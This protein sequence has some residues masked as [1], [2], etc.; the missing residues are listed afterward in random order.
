MSCCP[1]TFFAVKSGH[2]N[3]LSR[4][5]LEELLKVNDSGQ[6]LLHLATYIGNLKIIKYIISKVPCLIDYRNE[7]HE[8]PL[9]IAS[10]FGHINIINTFINTSHEVALQRVCHQDKN[11]TTCLFSAVSRNDNE[12]ALFL[13]K[14]FGKTLASLPNKNGMLPLHVA[15]LNGNIEFIR[16]CSKYDKD[17]VNI[18]DNYGYTSLMYAIQS[19][20]ITSIKYLVEKSKSNIKLKTSKAQNCLHISCIVGDTTIVKYFINLLGINSIL[21]TT[22]DF[23]NCFHCS[24]FHGN[25]N[26]I[27]VLGSYFDKKKRKEILSLKDSRGNTPLHLAAINDHIGIGK[28]L[29]SNDVN[30]KIMNNQ[31]QFP[32]DIAKKRNSIR[33]YNLIKSYEDKYFEKKIK[34]MVLSNGEMPTNSLIKISSCQNIN[35]TQKGLSSSMTTIARPLSEDFSVS[36]TYND[37]FHLSQINLNNNDNKFVRFS[38]QIQI[39][40]SNFFQYP[41]YQCKVIDD[42]EAFSVIA[43]IDKVLE[44]A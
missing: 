22:N 17:M 5:S 29:I 37:N 26:V 8:T 25:D 24:A 33:L 32:L 2:I 10:T 41:D 3:C 21:E 9:L 40:A 31:M 28:Y 18:K 27:K 16:I 42:N 38:Q 19:K 36:S 4:Y 12:T 15:A 39:A 7:L 6:S 11:G 14:R 34:S 20:C 1:S 23:A 43:E 35:K 44:N 13:L 30:T